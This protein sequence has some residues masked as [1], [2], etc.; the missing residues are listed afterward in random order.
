MIIFL[1]VIHSQVLIQ[2]NNFTPNL[3]IP[4]ASRVLL[5]V[6]TA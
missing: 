3:S 4:Q 2:M 1:V 5:M 6:P